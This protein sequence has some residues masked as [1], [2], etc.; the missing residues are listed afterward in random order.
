MEIEVSLV[1]RLASPPTAKVLEEIAF[2]TNPDT[3]AGGIFQQRIDEQVTLTAMDGKRNA[4]EFPVG[5]DIAA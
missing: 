3:L 1:K 2:R 4:F 5:R